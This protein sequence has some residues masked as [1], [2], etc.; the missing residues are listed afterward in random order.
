LF[1]GGVRE[2]GREGVGGGV[3]GEVGEILWWVVELVGGYFVGVVMFAW[4]LLEDFG[5]EQAKGGYLFLE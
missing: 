5:F 3:G 2:G 1:E 4:R